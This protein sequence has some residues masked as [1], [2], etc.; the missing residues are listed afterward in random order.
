MCNLS[1]CKYFSRKIL[2]IT[3]TPKYPYVTHATLQYNTHK[4]KIAV[5]IDEISSADE[6]SEKAPIADKKPEVKKPKDKKFGAVKQVDE[7]E[8][9]TEKPKEKSAEPEE[10]PKA[11]KIG[12]KEK[13]PEADEQKPDEE[14]PKAKKTTEA[15]RKSIGEKK[16]KKAEEPVESIDEPDHIQAHTVNEDDLKPASKPSSRRGSKKEKSPEKITPSIEVYAKF[17]KQM[18]FAWSIAPLTLS[19]FSHNTKI[20]TQPIK[21]KENSKSSD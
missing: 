5:Q 21:I 1:P 12:A 6:E 18:S 16:A 2:F 11:K 14:K 13:S 17:V 3:I 9:V 4:N 10:K 20:Q 19:K 8:I 15:K 7:E